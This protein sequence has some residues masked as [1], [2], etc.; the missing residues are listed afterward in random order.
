MDL[1]DD[2]YI[3]DERED[4]PPENTN[5]RISL[6]LKALRTADADLWYCGI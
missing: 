6:L 4:C 5:L 1:H 2:P 3:N